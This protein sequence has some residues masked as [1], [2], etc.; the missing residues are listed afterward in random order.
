MTTNSTEISN[1]IF[2]PLRSWAEQSAGNWNML[3]GSG[4]ILLIIACILAYAFYKKIG[5]EDERT[6]QIS[7]NSAFI[8]LCVVI[9]CDIVFPKDY[10]WQVFFLFKYSFAILAAGIYLAV[11]YQKDFLS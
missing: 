10:M 4:F 3:I 8:L 2:E 5:D 1:A 7:L 11:R 9:F 6:K